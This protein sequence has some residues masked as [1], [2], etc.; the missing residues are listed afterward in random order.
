MKHL[1]ALIAAGGLISAAACTA[2]DSLLDEVGSSGAGA[3]AAGS[4]SAQAGS[5]QSGGGVTSKGGASSMPSAGTAGSASTDGG[6]AD[7]PADPPQCPDGQVWCPGCTVGSGLCG[8]GCPA[9]ACEPCSNVTTQE[10]CD[11]RIGCH[12]VFQ[13]GN[14]CSCPGAG[15]CMEFRTCADGDTVDC[16][17]KNVQCD[18]LTPACASPAF[19]NSYSGFCYEGCVDSKDCAPPVCAAVNDG[20][21]C[22]SDAECP[23]D[24]RCYSA[25]C[26]NDS[27]GT[28]REP[29]PEGCFGDADCPS[30]QTCI[31]GRPAP[32]GTTIVDN[33]GTCGVEACPEGDCPGTAGPTCTCSEGA[34][35]VLA[36]GPTGTGRCRG[37]DGVCSI[38]KCASPETPIATPHGERRIADLRP[39]DLVYSVDGDAIRA[40]PIVRVNRTPVVGHH[41]LHVTFES[42]RFIDMTA[43]HPLAD[44]RPLSVLSAGT[45]LMGGV[46]SSVT[47]VAYTHPATY[48]ILPDS[49]SG[50]YFASGVLIG[51]TLA[52]SPH[53]ARGSCPAQATAW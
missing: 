52:G 46:V 22:Y 23:S 33:V 34:Q 16:Q 51:S 1:L 13:E 28:C 48:D 2:R 35:C 14:M 24:R 43:E 30:G 17:G 3:A 45:Q 44:G 47:R 42:G 36:T 49:T 38:C 18:A 6:A 20:C 15:C 8:V 40:V 32:C 11:L 7:V 26:A 12:S 9:A 10:A 25:D 29:P 19:V 41:V 53:R 50:A 31:G 21:A 5:A 37:P 39:G 27:P 4:A